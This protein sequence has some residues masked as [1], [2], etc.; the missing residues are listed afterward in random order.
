[1]S[2]RIIEAMKRYREAF[3]INPNL[4]PFEEAKPL[5]PVRPEEVYDAEKRWKRFSSYLTVAYPE[6]RDG[7]IESGIDEISNTKFRIED[8]LGKKISGRLLLKRDDSLP[9][10]GSVKARGG[11][12]EVLKHAE[13]LALEK[14][15]LRED[16]DYEK[17]HSEDFRRFFSGYKIQVGST[18]NLGLSIGI[19]AARLGFQVIVHMS[20]DAKEWKKNLL[21]EKGATV[22]EYEEDYSVAVEEGR[23]RSEADPTS[24]FVDDEQSKELFLGYAV[25]GL[26]VKKQLDRLGVEVTEKK[27]L[28]CYLP[29]GVGGAPGGLVYGLKL[30]FGDHVRC[31][32]AE[33][34]HSPCML[35]GMLSGKGNE[36]SVEDIGLDN[37]TEADGLAV[38]RPSAFVGEMME[39]LLSG[40]YTLNDERLFYYMQTLYREDGIFVEPSAAA[41]FLGTTML[42]RMISSKDVTHLVWAT[43]GMFVPEE[44]RREWLQRK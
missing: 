42:S 2:N 31:F 28:F 14:G 18:G 30:A 24:H 3:W 26:R 39:H 16:M 33:P 35:L 17:F 4:L 34:T 27:P 20:R 29:C 40:A 10:A 8:D 5:L 25:G 22:I 7:V 38:G 23:K 41:G 43:G 37:K 19:S 12:Y 11:I 15:I 36:I 1:M 21:R 9:I 6:I 13:T 44:L 32:F